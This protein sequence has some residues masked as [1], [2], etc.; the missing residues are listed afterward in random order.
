MIA[1]ILVIPGPM[2][3]TL[4]K[5]LR[6]SC[7]FEGFTNYENSAGESV[8][9]RD[10]SFHFPSDVRKASGFRTCA[11][12]QFIMQSLNVQHHCHH[13]QTSL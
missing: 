3:S 5:E 1:S 6:S 10:G 2:G 7:R 8:A 4:D 12:E 13:S 9:S 11:P